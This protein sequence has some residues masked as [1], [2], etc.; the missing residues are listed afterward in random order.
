MEMAAPGDRGLLCGTCRE[1]YW[2]ASSCLACCM[3]LPNWMVP[4]ST[5][6]FPG[7]KFSLQQQM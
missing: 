4:A 5:K 3:A 1:G 6:R 2:A 7:S